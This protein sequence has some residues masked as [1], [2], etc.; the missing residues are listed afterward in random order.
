ME[1]TFHVDGEYL[2]ED[3]RQQKPPPDTMFF[4]YAM[5]FYEQHL[6][7]LKRYQIL[8][9]STFAKTEGLIEGV[10]FT[11]E[12]SGE[13]LWSVRDVAVPTEK[14]FTFTQS[15]LEELA[16]RIWEACYLNAVQG[17]K[18]PDR[19]TYINNLINEIKK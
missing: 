5:G 19:S 11:I 6:R 13:E 17:G 4:R 10:D 12:R 7:E 2:Q 8:P 14:S 1:K 16:G 18:N 15:E 9:G 3:A